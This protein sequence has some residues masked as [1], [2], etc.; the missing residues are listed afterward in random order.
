MTLLAAC[1]ALAFRSFR[2]SATRC[3]AV[4]VL[5]LGAGVGAAAPP[6]SPVPAEAAPGGF[7]E[8]PA[9]AE[10]LRELRRGGYVL[11]M[12]HGTTDNSQSDRLPL[13]LQDCGAQRQLNAEGRRLMREVGQAI[14]RARIPIAD[15]RTSPMC[16]TR[17]SAALAFPDLRA[18]IDPALVYVANFTEAQKAP[19][20]AN[21]RRWLS[22]PVPAGGNRLLVG[23][24]PNVM[25]LIGHFPKEGMVVVFRPLDGERFEYV[26]SIP[27]QAWGR[28]APP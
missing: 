25:E 26:A 23:H 18:Q 24:A 8:R 9:S 2:R 21:T 12:R 1:H 15:L 14:R 28:L 22:T 10:L 4:V 17:E 3:L 20:L 27:A 19:V 7:T 11:Y 13:D 6:G 16:R 5:A